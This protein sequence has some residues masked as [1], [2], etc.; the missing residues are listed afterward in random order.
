MNDVKSSRWNWGDLGF[1]APAALL[2]ATDQGFKG[3][4]AMSL[5]MLKRFPLFG[6]DHLVLARVHNRG[7]IGD[8]F[9]AIPTGYIEPYTMYFPALCLAAFVAMIAMRWNSIGKWQRVFATLLIAGGA[10]NLLDN[11]HRGYVIDT[12]QVAMSGGTYLPFNLA[13]I[14][15]TSGTAV[16]VGSL[17]RELWL[18]VVGAGKPMR[19]SRK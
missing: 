1:Y 19:E 11:V 2:L 18:D 6:Q 16:L 7:L 10:S 15:I 9:S 13:D 3:W 14:G 12:L 4:V 17:L 8:R 5:P